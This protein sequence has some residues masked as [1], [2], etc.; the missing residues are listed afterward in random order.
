MFELF[1]R[2]NTKLP[3]HQSKLNVMAQL[4]PSKLYWRIS[5]C[6]KTYGMNTQRSEIEIGAI[7][8]LESKFKGKVPTDHHL[9]CFY[10]CLHKKMNLARNEIQRADGIIPDT[11]IATCDDRHVLDIATIFCPS[12]F[13][14][15]TSEQYCG[16]GHE[17]FFELL[18][19][20]KCD[21][22]VRYIMNEM[23]GENTI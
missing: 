13:E 10:Q 19:C 18:M 1:C 23:M 3:D 8:I 22:S 7:A 5:E 9:M 4:E 12:R 17:R 16:Y 15:W 20:Y 21:L 11:S 2:L 6:L 14:D